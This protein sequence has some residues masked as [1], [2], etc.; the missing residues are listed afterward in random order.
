MSFTIYAGLERSFRDK[1]KE[2]KEEISAFEEYLRC[3]EKSDATMEK[4]LRDVRSF[5]GGITDGKITKECVMEHKKELSG[6]FRAASVN[7]HLSAVNCFLRFMGKEECCVK[8]LKI[9]RQMFVEE[10]R[11]ITV[12]EYKRLVKAAGETRLGYIIRTIC[13]TG[14]RV[15]ELK[16]ITAEALERGKAVI[17]CK[18]KTRTIF[19]PRQ[20]QEL[21]GKYMKENHI[22]E[23]CIFITRNG[24]PINRSN[25]WKQMK[26][27]CEKA[28]IPPEKVFPHNLRHLFARTFYGMEKD[29]VQLADLLGHSSIN[30]TR[31]YTI[32]SGTRHRKSLEEVNRILFTT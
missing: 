22:T 20:V 31:I 29:I 14:I 19:I 15:S 12:E 24:K 18:N 6:Q 4:Y 7:S 30:T 10:E 9:Q 13:G 28:Q 26:A 23:G 21:L 5:C 11:E 16:Y 8:L 32:E 2:F 1:M 3:E 17:E 27:L 25:I